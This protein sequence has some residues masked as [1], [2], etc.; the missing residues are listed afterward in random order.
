L[1]MSTA[2]CEGGRGWGVN[3]LEGDKILLKM[4]IGLA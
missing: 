3:K 2:G 1:K 4:P